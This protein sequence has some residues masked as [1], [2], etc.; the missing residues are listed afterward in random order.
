MREHPTFHTVHHMSL[1]HGI[2]AWRFIGALH[3]VCATHVPR[4][5]RCLTCKEGG[6][7]CALFL[8]AW[9]GLPYPVHAEVA[10]SALPLVHQQAQEG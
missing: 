8:V 10:A 9:S 4:S 2:N 6:C 7:S 1:P 5:S 3:V